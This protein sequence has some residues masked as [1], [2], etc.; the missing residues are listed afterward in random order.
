MRSVQTESSNAVLVVNAPP[1]IVA[2]PT[3]QMILLGA[4]AVFSVLAAGTAPLAY[5]WTFGGTN[6]A[7]A[8]NNVLVVTNVQLVIPAVT[9]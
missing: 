8:T 4:S 3:D 2:Q 7:G 6:L 5:Q 9:Q 1:T